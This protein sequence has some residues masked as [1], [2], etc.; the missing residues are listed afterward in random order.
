MKRFAL[1]ASVVVGLA[2]VC[3]AA[4]AQVV[5]VYSPVVGYPAPVTTYYAPA[6][7]PVT[8]YYAPAP[9]TSYY[10][11]SA[12]PVTA[13]YGAA[14]VYVRGPVVVPPRYVYPGQPVRNFFR[15]PRMLY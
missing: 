5:T 7:Y 8:T 12:V 11:P 2:L 4:Q 1:T 15:G 14:P 13:Y 9:V 6:P 3:G 10:A